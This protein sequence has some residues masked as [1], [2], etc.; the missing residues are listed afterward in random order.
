MTDSSIYSF[1][2]KAAKTCNIAGL[3]VPGPIKKPQFPVRDRQMSQI[4]KRN[5]LSCCATK[6]GIHRKCGWGLNFAQL[7]MADWASLWLVVSSP[8]VHCVHFPQDCVGWMMKHT[9]GRSSAGQASW[10][11]SRHSASM[12]ASVLPQRRCIYST[13]RNLASM[14]LPFI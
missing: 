11:F 8:P 14:L 9:E 7:T 6:T 1:L 13:V 5:C 12:C 3:G 2:I 10:G 4:L